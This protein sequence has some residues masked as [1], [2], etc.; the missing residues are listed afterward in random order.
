MDEKNG[1]R[2]MPHSRIIGKRTIEK[3]KR[4]LHLESIYW[5]MHGNADK[6]NVKENHNKKGKRDIPLSLI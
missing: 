5:Y 4:K 1:I 2:L 3:W 6:K